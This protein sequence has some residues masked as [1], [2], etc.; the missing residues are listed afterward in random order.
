MEKSF[1]I[2]SWDQDAY[3]RLLRFLQDSA[4]EKYRLFHAKLVLDIGSF[5]GVRTPALRKLSA[6]IAKGDAKGFLAL[7]QKNSY[8]ERMLYGFVTGLYNWENEQEALARVLA[9]IPFIDNWAVCDMCT[10]SMRQLKKYPENGFALAKECFAQTQTYTVR[11]GAVA[12]LD[13]YLTPSYIDEMLALLCSRQHEAYY[14]KMA[15]AWALAEAFAK[16]KDKTLAAL[17]S[18]QDDFIYNKALQKCIESFRVSPE[19][20]LLLKSMKRK[21]KGLSTEQAMQKQGRQYEKT[22]H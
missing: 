18:V 15:V 16:E 12:M 7:C 3:A 19:D 13:Y 5:Y 20:K 17:G 1:C 8:E 10:A 4:D 9:F 14:V 11:F 6:E 2:E 21:T 22:D